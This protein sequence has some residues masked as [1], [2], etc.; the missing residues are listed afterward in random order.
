MSDGFGAGA[1]IGVVILYLRRFIPESPRW[2][3]TH[4]QLHEVERIVGD[5]EQTVSSESGQRLNDPRKGDSI[6]VQQRRRFGLTAIL[7]PMLTT[8]RSRSVLGLSL[9]IAQ[10]FLYNAML[11]TY[12]LVLARYY[13]V[14]SNHAG[15]YLLPFAPGNFLG[16]L[17]LGLLRYRRPP[18]DDRRD[19]HDSCSTPRAERIFVLAW[20]VE[21]HQPD[22]PLDRNVL[23]CLARR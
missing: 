18:S 20:R 22:H 4:G 10:A 1:V 23:F 6:K 3:M 11:F 16:P 9:M 8:L 12:A 14:P 21:R 13:G 2:L 7:K 5:V 15:L 17:A 19:I